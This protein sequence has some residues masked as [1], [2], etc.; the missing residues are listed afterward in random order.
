LVD[1]EG[2]YIPIVI[3][4]LRQGRNTPRLAHFL[5]RKLNAVDGVETQLFD[6][7]EMNLPILPERLQYLDAP[8][9]ALV[10]F[11][12]AIARAAAVVI[13]TPEYNKGYPAALKNMIDALGPEW[14]RKPIGIATHSVGAFAGVAVLQ[15]LRVVMLNL[16]AVPIPAS[17]TVPHIER[18]FDAKGVALDPAFESRAD[19]FLAEVV[20]YAATLRAA[21]DAAPE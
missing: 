12:A 13:T 17:V 8:P 14:K 10:D 7:R 16:G 6:P 4:S 11:G 19:R 3:G 2:M 15:A 1:D 18:A 9:A 5:H 21:A 20:W